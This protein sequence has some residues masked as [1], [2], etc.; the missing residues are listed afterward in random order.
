MPTIERRIAVLEGYV[1]SGDGISKKVLVCVRE[2]E[3]QGEALAR[4]GCSPDDPKSMCILLVP[5][6]MST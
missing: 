2:G 3:T 4:V 1:N 5:L 6:S